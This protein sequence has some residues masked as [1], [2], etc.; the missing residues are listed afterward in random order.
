MTMSSMIPFM[1]W[2]DALMIAD[3]D[4]ACAD[5]D[6]LSCGGDEFISTED[7]AEMARLDAFADALF[8]S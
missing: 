8:V 6:L 2:V 3:D 7:G 4:G 5:D 1:D